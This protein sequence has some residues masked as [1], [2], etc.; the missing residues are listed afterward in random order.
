MRIK[1]LAVILIIA[2]TVLT[3]CKT[4][5]NNQT[6]LPDPQTGSTVTTAK[7]FLS[8]H[9]EWTSR[10]E[11]IADRTNDTYNDWLSGKINT[12]E[13]LTKLQSFLKEMKDLNRETD[14][15]TDFNLSV[16]DKQR[17]NYDVIVKGYGKASKDLNDFL[18]YAPHL[19]DE[20][21]KVKYDEM[22]KNKFKSDISELKSNLKM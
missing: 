12:E 8:F 11:G 22:I 20:Q 7:D 6:N 16:N 5:K 1:T 14:L 3:G 9:K 13:L 19:T 21:I 10:L 2:L 18:E 17:V 4:F 15:K